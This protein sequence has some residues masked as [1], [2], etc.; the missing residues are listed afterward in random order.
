MM[1]SSET[2]QV[3]NRPDNHFGVPKHLLFFAYTPLTASH[4]YLC[5]IES[6]AIHNPDHVVK[7]FIP[8]PESVEIKN[9]IQSVRL[10]DRVTVEGLNYTRYFSGTQ[11]ESWYTSGR[12]S[13]STW[14][15]QNLGNAFRLALL[16]HIGGTY[17]DMD[18]I[19][20]NSL[21]NR[22]EGR[23]CARE[24]SSKVNNA[25]ISTKPKD[26]FIWYKLI[27]FSLLLKVCYGNV[28]S[29]LSRIRLV[30]L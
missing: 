19:S 11:L 28:Y 10:G 2:Q 15:D 5:S 9:W 22:V 18:I 4:K 24:D 27:P 25:F 23:T 7:L 30:S 1:T 6:A 21:S 20:V 17:M 26:P 8:N 29:E 3:L 14:P 13:R 12:F 16:W